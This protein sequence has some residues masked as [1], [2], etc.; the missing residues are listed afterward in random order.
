MVFK[1]SMLNWP[2]GQSAIGI[3][4]LFYIYRSTKFGV[5]IFKSSLLK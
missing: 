3:C 5:V 2:G 1:V 4:T